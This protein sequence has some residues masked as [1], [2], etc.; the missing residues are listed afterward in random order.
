MCLVSIG[1]PSYGLI[2]TVEIVEIAKE[3]MEISPNEVCDKK[4][5][6]IRL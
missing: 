2:N 5:I 1:R 4:S 6:D 3:L